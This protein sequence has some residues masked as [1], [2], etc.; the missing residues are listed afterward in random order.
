MNERELLIAKLRARGVSENAIKKILAFYQDLCP[1]YKKFIKKL[2][3]RGELDSELR[4]AGLTEIA[5]RKRIIDIYR[6]KA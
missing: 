2:K 1:L 3:A 5:L 4:K 6:K